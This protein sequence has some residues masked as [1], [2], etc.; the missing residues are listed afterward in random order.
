MCSEYLVSGPTGT[1]CKLCTKI[2]QH[3]GNARRHMKDVHMN[4]G[5]SYR[6]PKCQRDYSSGN[7]FYGHL[8]KYHK[9]LCAFPLDNFK[10]E[11]QPQAQLPPP[12]LQ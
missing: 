10:I 3:A 8:Y 12:A 9:E 7:S 11:K 5:D 2:I 4:L 6:C 1:L